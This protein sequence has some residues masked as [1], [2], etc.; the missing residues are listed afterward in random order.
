MKTRR[1]RRCA[2]EEKNARI[3]RKRVEHMNGEFQ[4]H[5]HERTPEIFIPHESHDAR[6]R[7]GQRACGGA[8]QIRRSREVID[9]AGEG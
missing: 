1:E 8:K 2:C 3:P 6:Q 9:V 7:A 5:K 4:T